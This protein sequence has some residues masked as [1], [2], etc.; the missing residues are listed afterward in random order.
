MG[1]FL[2]IELPDQPCRPQQRI[3]CDCAEA[4]QQGVGCEPV[5]PAAGIGAPFH[6][7]ALQQRAQR[8]PLRQRRDEAAAGEGLVPEGLM[9]GVTPAIFERHAAEYE[10][11]QH[12]DDQRIGRGQD[13][14]IGERESGKQA[15]SPQHQPG[16]VPVPHR[17]DRVHRPVTLAPCGEGREQDADA[18]IEAVHHHIGEDGKGDDE[19]PDNGQIHHTGSFSDGAEGSVSSPSGFWV[20]PGVMPAVRIGPVSPRLT[21]YSPAC[22]ALPIS[23]RIYHTPIPNTVK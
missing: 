19:G 7:D 14:R 5:P 11:Q 4:G 8:H 15:P 3:A 17:R 12:R 9:P 6:L 23:L 22:G 13:H 18:E 20:G 21:P 1:L 16:L 2:A 10:A